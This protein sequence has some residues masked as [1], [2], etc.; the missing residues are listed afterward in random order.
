MSP[1]T[2]WIKG[3]GRNGGRC[4]SVDSEGHD[5][6]H[7]EALIMLQLQ[8]IEVISFHPSSQVCHQNKGMLEVKPVIAVTGSGQKIQP[9]LATP[10]LNTLMAQTELGSE[11]S[12]LNQGL[13]PIPHLLFFLPSSS[14]PQSLFQEVLTQTTLACATCLQPSSRA[15]GV[16]VP[17][18]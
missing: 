15:C 10:A 16:N 7:W 1:Q 13:S 4:C 12:L 8:N 14:Q 5:T 11:I 3:L 9:P 6:S 2:P 17:K 18:T